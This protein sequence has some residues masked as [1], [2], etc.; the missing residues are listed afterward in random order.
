LHAF[1]LEATW[2]EAGFMV[3]SLSLALTV[4]S[5]PGFIGVFQYVGQQALVVPFGSK[6]DAGTALAAT[7][8]AHLVYYLITTAL[9]IVGLWRFGG[10]LS[11]LG[12]RIGRS[13]PTPT[14]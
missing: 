13:A 3:V 11:G 5:S 8:T 9:G 7:L 6:F 4:P 1:Q 14:G 2:I 10:S 12:R